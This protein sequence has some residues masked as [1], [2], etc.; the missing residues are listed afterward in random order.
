LLKSARATADA[1]LFMIASMALTGAVV[2]TN[3]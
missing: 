2:I 1:G 3:M